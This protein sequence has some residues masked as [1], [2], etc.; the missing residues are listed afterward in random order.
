MKIAMIRL[1]DVG[2]GGYYETRENQQK[3]W[4]VAEYLHRQGV[5]FQVAVIPRFV[6]PPR[7]INR[8]MADASNPVSAGYLRAIRGMPALGATLGMH[9]FTHQYGNAVSAEGYEFHDG[10]CT[11]DCPPDDSPD[12]LTRYDKFLLSYAYRRFQ[13]ALAH[14]RAAGLRPDWFET[15]HYTASALQRRLLEA[16]SGVM[17]E[18]NPEKP[19]S[20]TIS[21]RAPGTPFSKGAWYVPTP[22]SYVGGA[23]VEEDVNRICEQMGS[24]E[25]RDIA[26]FFFHPF[27]EFPYIQLRSGQTP[28]Y[29]DQSPLHRLIWS[30]LAEGR[31]F[32]SILH[33]FRWSGS[34]FVQPAHRF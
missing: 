19:G 25:E 28:L 24:Y 1:E 5:P 12:T 4:T 21:F 7:G 32:V 23:S 2:P 3:L 22:L 11:E 17:H 31:R 26:S 33:L 20:R 10:S 15:P 14:F 8:S 9:G 27:L 18:E 16:C 29:S 13:R 30:F 6:D 34:P